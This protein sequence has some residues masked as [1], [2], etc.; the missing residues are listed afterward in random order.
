MENMAI[1]FAKEY[2]KEET[3]LPA[4]NLLVYNAIASNDG[5]LPTGENLSVLIRK[6]KYTDSTETRYRELGDYIPTIGVEAEIPTAFRDSVNI[7]NIL[8]GLGISYTSYEIVD[9]DG[10]PVDEIRPSYSY[11]ALTQGRI[12]QECVKLGIKNVQEEHKE[13][14]LHVNLGFDFYQKNF[15]KR[16]DSNVKI[17][18]A[19]IAFAFVTPDRISKKKSRY[20]FDIKGGH[21]GGRN[22]HRLEV[23]MTEFDNETTF[24]MLNEVQLIAS[25]LFADFKVNHSLN[26]NNDEKRLELSKVFDKFKTSVLN[27]LGD[28][29]VDIYSNFS[30][31][32]LIRGYRMKNEHKIILL[33]QLFTSTA[34]EIK[35]ILNL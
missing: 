17:F 32:H 15:M 14:S 4:V 28:E 8:I 26:K 2:C 20:M 7:S 13:T 24:R 34:K 31:R 18:T 35:K 21:I 3:A 19:A 22:P 23:K 6:I 12:L 9:N 11:S 10:Y 30:S 1:E 29:G 25:S 16:K 33:R 27:N 5:E